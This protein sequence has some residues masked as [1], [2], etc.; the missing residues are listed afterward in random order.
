MKRLI[1]FLVVVV[2]VGVVALLL[3]TFPANREAISPGYMEADLVLVGSEQGGRVETLS[4]RRATTST[5]VT[6]I[7]TL[8]STEQEA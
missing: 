4:V 6:A 2:I 7:F 3:T 5:R 1:A 8:E